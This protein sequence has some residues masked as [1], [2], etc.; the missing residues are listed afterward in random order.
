L[1]SLSKLFRR[2]L[3][4]QQ[5]GQYSQAVAVYDDI[6]ALDDRQASAHMG[7][8]HALCML[9]RHAEA[10]E[11]YDHALTIGPDLAEAHHRRSWV[12]FTLGRYSDA[13]ASLDRVVTLAQL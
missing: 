6:I 7:R 9:G 2:A 11:S 12:L 3:E 5:N 13:L 1:A 4:R 10:L 8:G